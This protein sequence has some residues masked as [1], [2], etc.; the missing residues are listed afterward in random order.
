M[1]ELQAENATMRVQKWSTPNT[2]SESQLS[3]EPDIELIEFT[4]PSELIQRYGV[5]H[6][7]CRYIKFVSIPG[8][9]S[10]SDY[11]VFIPSARGSFRN[12]LGETLRAQHKCH[13]GCLIR[14]CIK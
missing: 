6:F 8:F 2:D 14:N 5:V 3:D 11:W 4:A 13:A 10:R 7:C 9:F 1:G 12:V